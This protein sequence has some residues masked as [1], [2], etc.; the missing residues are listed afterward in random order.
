ME[1]V[2]QGT[3]VYGNAP[4]LHI[5]HPYLPWPPHRNYTYVMYIQRIA[6]SIG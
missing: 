2:Y 1:A 5:P 4:T 6:V 3:A